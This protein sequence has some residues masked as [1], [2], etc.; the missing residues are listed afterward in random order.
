MARDKDINTDNDP[1]TAVERREKELTR[2]DLERARDGNDLGEKFGRQNIGPSVGSKQSLETKKKEDEK[3]ENA[4][5]QLLQQM[6]EELTR[7]LQEL[8]KRIA[9][10]DGKI[11]AIR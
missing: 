10:T 11:E 2:H 1:L 9:E 4:M 7:Q 8:D 6:R 5:R 3:F